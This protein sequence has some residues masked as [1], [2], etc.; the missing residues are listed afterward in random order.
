MDDQARERLLRPLQKALDDARA[1]AATA[2]EYQAGNP[3]VLALVTTKLE[4]AE[5]WLTKAW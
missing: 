4:E 1:A 3:R 2:V 5:L